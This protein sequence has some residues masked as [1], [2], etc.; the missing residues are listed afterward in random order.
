MKGTV[1][2]NNSKC[3]QASTNSYFFNLIYSSVRKDIFDIEVHFVSVITA[4]MNPTT[5]SNDQKRDSKMVE[6]E[7]SESSSLN[8]ILCLYLVFFLSIF[9]SF[10]TFNHTIIH[11]I[12]LHVNRNFFFS[13]S[14]TH[15]K[16]KKN[17]S[18]Y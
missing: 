17:Y 12:I 1:G 16:K 18:K 11:E 7:A 14:T 2:S 6:V 5:M 4:Q 15:S 10:P 3:N 13:F 8:V 9:F